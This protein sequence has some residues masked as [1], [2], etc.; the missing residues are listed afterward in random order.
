MAR[1]N[2]HL[3]PT[4]ID[5]GAKI[6]IVPNEFIKSDDFVGETLKFKGV[7]AG[8]EWTKAHVA[9][10]PMSIG[11]EPFVEKVLVVLGK[12]LE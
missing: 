2:G 3:V 5:S 10:V 12:D 11:K 6:S 8:Y 7:L 4:T 9:K 1:V